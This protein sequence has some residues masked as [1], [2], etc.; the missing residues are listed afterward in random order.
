MIPKSAEYRCVIQ[1]PH[2]GKIAVVIPSGK[3]QILDFCTDRPVWRNTRGI[4][5]RV[6]LTAARRGGGWDARFGGAM[7]LLWM[8]PLGTKPPLAP[9]SE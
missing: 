5:A 1:R 4:T 7:P 6:P 3:S 2:G 8:A 9:V